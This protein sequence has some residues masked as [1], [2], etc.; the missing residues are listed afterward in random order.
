MEFFGLS[1]LL[2]LPAGVVILG[3]IV[4]YIIYNRVKESKKEDFEKRD[5]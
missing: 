3:I 4:F 1:L 5:N 2:M